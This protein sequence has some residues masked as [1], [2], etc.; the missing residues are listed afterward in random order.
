MRVILAVH[1]AGESVAVAAHATV[2][3]LYVAHLHGTAA[4]YDSWR[5]IGFATVSAVDR[6]SMQPLTAFLPAPYDGLPGT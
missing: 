2:L 3:N 6:A 4:T 1:P 5:G